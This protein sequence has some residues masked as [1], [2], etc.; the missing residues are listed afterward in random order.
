MKEEVGVLIERAW[1]HSGMPVTWM[2]VL[3]LLLGH[4]VIL[5]KSHALCGPHSLYLYWG[6]LRE[7]GGSLETLVLELAQ[8][9]TGSYM[10]FWASVFPSG[11]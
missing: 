1:P 5:L 8:L 11:K 6:F 7:C 10:L 9:P 3:A 2:S 4:T